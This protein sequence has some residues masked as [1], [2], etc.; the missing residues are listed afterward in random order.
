[1]CMLILKPGSFE[2]WHENRI[3]SFFTDS[4]KYDVSQ[5]NAWAFK[6][7]LYLFPHF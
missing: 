3:S 7:D 2:N 1:M 4:V 6:S 5:R